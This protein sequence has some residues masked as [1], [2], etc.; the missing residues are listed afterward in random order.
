MSKISEV[1]LG[2]G[3][4]FSGK[5]L[6]RLAAILSLAF[7]VA[8]K[9]NAQYGGGGGT[10]GTGSS[11]GTYTAPSGGYGSGKAAGIGAGAAAGAAAGVYFLVHYHGRVTGCVQPGA[12]GMHLLD[13]KKNKSYVLV[14]G[15][16]FLKP[17]QRVLLK[18][19]KTTND[20]GDQEFT[21]KK[22][23]KDLGTCDAQTAEASTAP[24]T[25]R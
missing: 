11:G 14:P 8:G 4:Y 10:G 9:A 22:L 2:E 24:A 20:K 19:K 16:V 21:A 5:N 6:C 1:R 17:G 7:A 12:D 23:L 13:D 25:G 18:G 3:E 15:D